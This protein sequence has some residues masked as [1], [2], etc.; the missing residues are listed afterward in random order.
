MEEWPGKDKMET[1]VEISNPLFIFAS[2]ICRFLEDRLWSPTLRLDEFLKDPA[3]RSTS[4]MERTYLPIL[5]LL[6]TCSSETDSKKLE[7]EFHEIIG[8]II[9]LAMPLSVNALATL[10]D[11]KEES[12]QA[13]VQ[14]FRS[15]LSV[16]GDP[17]VPVR[18]LHQSFRDFLLNTTSSYRIHETATHRK[19]GLCCLR[20]LQ[21]RLKR[22]I[23]NLSSYG[24]ER[25]GIDR[26]RIAQH[27]LPELQYSCRYWAYH[28]LR[29]GSYGM[30]VL[31][32][33]FLREHFLHWLEA[34]S[35]IGLASDTVG[36]INALRSGFK[37]SCYLNFHV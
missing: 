12:V 7:G 28:L 29:A 25:M 3:T 37:V 21:T 36:T 14:S 33:R 2:T 35:L 19:I 23:C 11:R 30:E 20:I 32:L 27:L 22:N 6:L 9:L 34:M 26:E 1:L 31:I 15:V 17:D 18:T 16:P 13:R 8:V 10:I 4:E 5:N 24:S